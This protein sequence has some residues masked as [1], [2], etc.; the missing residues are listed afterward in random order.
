MRGGERVRLIIRDS[1]VMRGGGGRSCVWLPCV[2]GMVTCE[3]S[4]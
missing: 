4:E 3:E 1:R 2:S